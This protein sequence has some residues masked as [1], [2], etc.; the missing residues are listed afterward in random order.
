[1]LGSTVARRG[2]V[3][4]GCSCA[5]VLHRGRGVGRV[6]NRRRSGPQPTPGGDPTDVGWGSNRRR[7]DPATGTSTLR[8]PSS[9]NTNCGGFPLGLGTPLGRR[10]DR[11]CARTT[12]P[13]SGAA[14][15]SGC[16]QREGGGGWGGES[17]P[18][19]VPAAMEKLKKDLK[20]V[21]DDVKVNK[22]GGTKYGRGLGMAWQGLVPSMVGLVPS[23]VWGG[24]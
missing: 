7:L 6:P 10:G 24:T 8:D 15:P 9:R 19:P 22:M 3:R 13:E 14:T 4:V 18:A 1:M 2:A 23:M 20:D 12:Q 5:P 17:E 11:K 21:N 16:R